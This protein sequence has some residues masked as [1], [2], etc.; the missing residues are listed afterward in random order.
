MFLHAKLLIPRSNCGVTN[1][2][3]P[4]R[5][6]TDHGT[7]SDGHAYLTEFLKIPERILN[8]WADRCSTARYSVGRLIPDSMQPYKQ[9][10]FLAICALSRGHMARNRSLHSAGGLVEFH[11]HI[12]QYKAVWLWTSARGRLMECQAPSGDV[13]TSYPQPF[14]HC[15]FEG[16][17]FL[18]TRY[19]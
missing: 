17:L 14:F 3:R 1:A 8:L 15:E 12:V 18:Y 16:L 7:W 4:L 9:R 13:R 10:C 6:A 2:I 5:A 19:Y 11:P